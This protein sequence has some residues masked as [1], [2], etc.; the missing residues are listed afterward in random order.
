MNKNFLL[1][2]LIITLTMVLHGSLEYCDHTVI[3]VLLPEISSFDSNLDE[4]FFGK[5]KKV[6]VEHITHIYDEDAIDELN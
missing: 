5:F 1:T 4:S 2:I 6:S 3:V